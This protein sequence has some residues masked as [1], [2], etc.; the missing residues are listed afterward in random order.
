MKIYCI[1]IVLNEEQYLGASIKS[2]HRHGVDGIAIVEGADKLYPLATDDGLSIDNTAQVLDDLML[3]ENCDDLKVAYRAVGHVENKAELWNQ[4]LALL[5][6]NQSIQPEDWVLLCCGDEIYRDD[7][8]ELLMGVIKANPT[9]GAIYITP[10]HFWKD[11]DHLTMGSQWDRAMPRAFRN[12]D[13][14]IGFVEHNLPPYVDG[15]DELDTNVSEFGVLRPAIHVHHYGAVKPDVLV[16]A[17]LAYYKERDK[18]L[19]VKDTFT[20]YKEGRPTQWTHGGGYVVETKM[21]HPVEINELI[22]NKEWRERW[23]V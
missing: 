22:N 19:N 18:D 6:E 7:Q 17:K 14:S 16:K 12:C 1:Y 23:G 2:Y 8:W 11:F 4:S 5:A 15:M 9:A 20:D 10:Y 3:D 21:D 13:G